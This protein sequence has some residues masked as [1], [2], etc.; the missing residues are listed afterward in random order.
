M[1][2]MDCVVDWMLFLPVWLSAFMGAS[3]SGAVLV[4][5]AGGGGASA[6][7]SVVVFAVVVVVVAAT[8]AI[9]S[10]APSSSILSLALFKPL[11]SSAPADPTPSTAFPSSPFF[12]FSPLRTPP[13]PSVG[14]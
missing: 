9:M 12:F 13:T 3:G 10:E 14:I 11:P 2:L 7:G 1:A 6:N 4:F 8:V 5:F